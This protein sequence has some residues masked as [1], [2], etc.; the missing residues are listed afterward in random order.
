MVL[1]SASGR[2]VRPA[3]ADTD[4]LLNLPGAIQILPGAV[5]VARTTYLDI[6]D[7]S[8]ILSAPDSSLICRPKTLYPTQTLAYP[9]N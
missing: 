6:Y 8:T 9:A 2:F 4:E 7:M 1:Q 3:A 5:A